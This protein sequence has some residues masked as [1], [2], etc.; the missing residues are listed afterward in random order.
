MNDDREKQRSE[1]AEALESEIR[2]SRKFSPQE[3]LS[4]MAGPGALKGASPVSQV[5]QAE[6][7]IGL[8]LGEHVTDPAGALPGLLHRQLKGSAL[9]LDSLDQ[10]LQAL[11]MHCRQVLASD[12]LMKEL[13][14]EAD[15]EWGRTMD[16]RPHFER[17]D[18]APHAD[19]PYTAESVREIIAAV[20]E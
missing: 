3:A 10:P 16:E 18:T 11:A 19:D 13:V 2:Q 17:E 1:A 4:R 15:V 5:Q 6:I 12:F 8:W 7:E 9:L 14:R 20:I